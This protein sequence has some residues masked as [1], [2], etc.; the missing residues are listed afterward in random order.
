LTWHAEKLRR[1][2]R[3][4]EGTL[5]QHELNGRRAEIRV[6]DVRHQDGRWVI[7]FELISQGPAAQATIVTLRSTDSGAQLLRRDL[8]LVRISSAS[9]GPESGPSPSSPPGQ[10]DLET[11]WM[12]AG[13]SAVNH[14]RRRARLVN[15]EGRPS[16]RLERDDADGVVE[17][18]NCPPLEA[19][20]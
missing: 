19:M 12:C 20:T 10:L 13:G 17:W 2:E 6:Y 11:R 15:V 3:T 16:Y 4:E 18:L 14:Y 8:G 5:R 1:R 9:A 7:N